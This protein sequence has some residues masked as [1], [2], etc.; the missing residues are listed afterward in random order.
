MLQY[1]A[2][3]IESVLLPGNSKL[4]LIHELGLF[5]ILGKE[6]KREV[7]TAR[8]IGSGAE[9]HYQERMSMALRCDCR[10]VFHSGM[11]I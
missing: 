9:A 2:T 6:E 8:K 11:G 3:T 4:P 5:G 1:D 7:Q 10:T